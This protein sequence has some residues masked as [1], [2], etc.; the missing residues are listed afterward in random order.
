MCHIDG[1]IT[2]DANGPA[3]GAFSIGGFPFTIKSGT[4]PWLV[5]HMKNI[6]TAATGVDAVTPFIGMGLMIDGNGYVRITSTGGNP[7]YAEAL[8][9]IGTVLFV[10][11]SYLI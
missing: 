8:M 6:N 7:Y 10:G 3:S 9:K 2:A 1:A 11:G 5:C 4:T